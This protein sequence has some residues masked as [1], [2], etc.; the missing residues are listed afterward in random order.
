MFR[1]SFT[2]RDLVRVVW[3]FLFTY[4]ST[5]FLLAD[6]WG[7]IT[8]WANAKA[9]AI[10]LAP[11]CLAAAFSAVKNLVLADGTTLKG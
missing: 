1:I 5:F 9:A 3:A 4:V 2:L 6:G 8:N 7:P 11:A 10:A